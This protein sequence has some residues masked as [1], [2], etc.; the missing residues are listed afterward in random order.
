MATKEQIAAVQWATKLMENKAERRKYAIE[1]FRAVDKDSSGTLDTEEVVALITNI[2]K[3]MNLSL[4]AKD[5]LDLLY[6]MCDKNNDGSLQEAEFQSFFKATLESAIKAAEASLTAQGV[7]KIGGAK[8][9]GTRTVVVGGK[10]KA[11]YPAEDEPAASKKKD[12]SREMASHTVATLRQSITPGTVLILLAGRFRGRRVVFLKQL[13]SSGLLLCTGP[14]GVNGVPLRR[15]NQAYAIATTTT[16]DVSKVDTAKFSDEYF[17][18]TKTKRKTKGGTDEMFV[19]KDAE[20]TGPTAERIADQQ[21]VDKALMPEIN[22]HPLMAKYLK[23]RFSLSK[24]DIP[25]KM[26]F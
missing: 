13:K 24:G 11:F 9:G 16:V 23:A 10:G 6:G 26:K 2:S 7:K 19:E 21:A 4:P 18:K 3:T 22:K 15:V 25:H 14:Y 17:G 8:N 5:K 20:K 12:L 1:Q